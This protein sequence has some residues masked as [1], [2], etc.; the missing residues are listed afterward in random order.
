VRTSALVICA[1][2]AVLGAASEIV[3]VTVD[4]VAD[5]LRTALVVVA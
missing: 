1:V 3:G 5:E 4:G 2:F